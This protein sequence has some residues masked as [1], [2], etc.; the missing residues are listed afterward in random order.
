MEVIRSA[1]EMQKKSFAFIR[2]S[3]TI[4]FVPTMGF[5][6]EG[7][8]AL[9]E[10]ARRE[11]DLVITSIFVNPLQFGPNEDYERYPRNEA[12]DLALAADAGVDLV[13]IPSAAEMYPAKM[14]ISL[15]IEERANV[16]CGR[17]RPGH[18]EGVLTVLAKLFHLIQPTKAYFGMK[19]AQQF[20]VVSALVDNLNFP[21]QLIAVPTVR[22]SDGLAKSSRNVNLDEKERKEAVSLY[23]A[24]QHGRQLVV[25]GEKN[26]AIIVKEVKE[27]IASQLNGKMDYV[28][29]WSYP[30]LEP[31]SVIDRQVILAIAVQFEKARLIDNLV[32]DERGCIGS[33]IR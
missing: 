8:V 25:D 29:L 12:N 28:E 15:T 10:Q 21:V 18:F 4:G 19:D 14:L 32:F 23:K 9:M 20:S 16:L 24:L 2:E 33:Q 6:H 1:A 3:K 30:A 11:N 5:F 22:E 7:H 26:P 13:F 31:V 27:Q 17:T